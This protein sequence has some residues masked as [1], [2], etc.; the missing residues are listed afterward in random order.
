MTVDTRGFFG[1][2]D[3]TITV[4]FDKPFPAEVQLHVHTYI[5]SDIV[6]QPGVVSF[7]PVQQGSEAKQ[8][9]AVSYAG[10]GDWRIDRVESANPSIVASVAE[11][12]RAAGQVAYTLST[13]LKADT[14]SGYIRDQLILVTND[15]DARSARVPVSVEG[16][17]VSALSVRPSPLMMGTAEVG[18]PVTRNLVV[19]GR[20]PFRILAA[21]CGDER[22]QCRIPADAKAAQIL[23]VTFLAED[24]KSPSGDV[25]AKLRIETDPTPARTWWR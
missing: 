24:P 10:R 9:V 11:T 3:A 23:P 19:Q 6:V 16:Q 14:P 21:K 18:K 2:K 7:G 5:R 1:R 25:K 4:V 13:Q 8:S 22:F 15:F 12:K 20:A 17:V